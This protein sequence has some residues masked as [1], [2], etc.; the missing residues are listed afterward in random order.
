MPAVESVTGVLI[1]QGASCGWRRGARAGTEVLDEK[2]DEKGGSRSSPGCP[3]FFGMEHLRNPYRLQRACAMVWTTFRG[4]CGRSRYGYG[5]PMGR[6]LNVGA[7]SEVAQEHSQVET[8][9]SRR[10][11]CGL[12]GWWPDVPSERI[13]RTV[14]LSGAS[15]FH[16]LGPWSRVW[17]Y[18]QSGRSIQAL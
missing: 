17:N 7:I 10:L 16:V 6:D 2:P 15:F 5:S 4:D 9:C 12:P 11:D 14:L 1:E 3:A 18:R 13:V 8:H